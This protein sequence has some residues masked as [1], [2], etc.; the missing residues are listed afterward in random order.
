MTASDCLKALKD[1]VQKNVADE[2]MLLKENTENEYVHPHVCIMTLPHKNFIPVDFSVP[3]ILIGLSDGTD[4]GNENKLSIRIMCAT[5]TSG[6]YDNEL[7]LPDDTG[8]I[9]LL[10]VIE[11]IILRLTERQVINGMGSLEKP[12]NYGVYSE[13]ATY[14]YNYGYLTFGMQI[15]LNE[16]PM[17]NNYTE[18]L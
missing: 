6:T 1:F 12:I 5:Y 14:P 9:D 10:N 2:M 11:R 13:Q 7:K 16:Y 18:F 8:Y 3:F 4:S 17:Y 15:P